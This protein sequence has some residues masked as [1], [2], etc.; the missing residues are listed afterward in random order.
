MRRCGL[1]IAI[2]DDEDCVVDVRCFGDTDIIQKATPAQVLANKCMEFIA[3][4]LEGEE[5]G[6]DT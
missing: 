1:T 3:K 6:N 5:S 2:E 4:E